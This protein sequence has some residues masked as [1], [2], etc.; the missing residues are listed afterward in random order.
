MK[1][2]ILV[3]VAVVAVVGG[4]IF[5]ISRVADVSPLDVETPEE[6]R[7][8]AEAWET[9]AA[10]A[11]GG[12]DLT[13]KVVDMVE[14]AREWLAGERPTEQF[15]AELAALE[16]RFAGIQERLR[17]LPEFPYDDRVDDLYLDAAVLYA[18][19]VEVYQAMV[20]TPESEPAVRV[21]LDRL[22]RRVRILG[23]RVFDRGRELVK[24]RLHQAPSPDVDMRLPDEVPDW[25]QEGIAPGPPLAPTE[26]PPPDGEPRLR[27]PERPAQA[28]DDWLA[29]VRTLDLPTHDEIRT[30][31]LDALPALADRLIDGAE[32]LRQTPDPDGDR[33]LSARVRLSLLI[34]AD[35]ARAR[36]MGLESVADSL[37]AVSE[38]L[39]DATGLP[40]RAG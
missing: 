39:W 23:D 15:R 3:V 22:A 32:E 13:E 24:P 31:E 37:F 8:K 12:I 27:A 29:A 20:D 36:Q 6:E 11:F 26:P 21:Q 2:A 7:A 19:T 40:D 5:G 18:Q 4:V 34:D 17:D 14:G 30:A 25:V 35:A 33:E 16:G 10:A 1:Q 28:R 9:E 38:D